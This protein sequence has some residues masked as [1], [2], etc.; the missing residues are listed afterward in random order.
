MS[1]WFLK[2]RLLA[3]TVVILIGSLGA[4]VYPPLITYLLTKYSFTSALII[5]SGIQLNCLVGS[6]LLQENQAPYSLIINNKKLLQQNHKNLSRRISKNNK[7]LSQTFLVENEKDK[8]QQEQQAAMSNSDNKHTVEYNTRKLNNEKRK[9]A[10]R[11]NLLI[12]DNSETQSTVS[13]STANLNNYTWKQYWRRFVQTRQNQANAKKNLFHLIAEEKKKTRTLSKSSLEDGFVI[14]TS[15]V[16]IPPNDEANVVVFGRQSK[17]AA[18]PQSRSASRFFTRIAN[19]IRSLG[20]SAKLP[21]YPPDQSDNS[22][23]KPNYSSVS[24]NRSPMIEKPVLNRAEQ[25]ASHMPLQ[26][27]SVFDR[28]TPAESTQT[29]VNEDKQMPTN[30][31]NVFMNEQPLSEYNLISENEL[32]YQETDSDEE[33]SNRKNVDEEETPASY[34]K[35]YTKQGAGGSGGGGQIIK[36]SRYLSYRNSL[37]NSVRGSL[38]ECSVP[39]DGVPSEFENNSDSFLKPKRGTARS[40]NNQRNSPANNKSKQSSGKLKSNK[41][42]QNS[43]GGSNKGMFSLVFNS[44]TMNGRRFISTIEAAS[45]LSAPINLETVEYNLRNPLIKRGAEDLKK[46]KRSFRKASHG[47]SFKY[48]CSLFGQYLAYIFSMKAAFNPLLLFLNLSFFFNIIGKS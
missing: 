48:T 1:K 24:I 21:A 35:N 3:S 15:N 7:S 11:R 12:A 23:L 13:T 46:N 28:P 6:T 38:M 42:N 14:T 10:L 39:E 27:M 44:S 17:Q 31:A 2:K 22:T 9:S 34:V 26:L 40:L 45:L 37:S 25:P 4:A 36:T 20:Q 47:Q 18:S 33:E 32:D 5:L 30:L 29:E 8:Q 16:L 43:G 19:S 41:S